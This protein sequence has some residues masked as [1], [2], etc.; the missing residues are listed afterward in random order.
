MPS[1]RGLPCSRESRRPSSS[2]RARIWLPARSRISNRSCGVDWDHV[3]SADF[4][5]AIARSR[6][7]TDAAANSPT[8]SFTFDG[9]ISAVR[10]LESTAWPSIRFGKVVDIRAPQAGLEACRTL[11]LRLQPRTRDVRNVTVYVAHG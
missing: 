10:S 8:T 2:L 3:V 7:A 4:A 9:L 6:S 5:D 11:P 1:A